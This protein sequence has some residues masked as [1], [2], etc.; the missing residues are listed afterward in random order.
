MTVFGTNVLG[1]GTLSLPVSTSKPHLATY[2]Y[3]SSGLILSMLCLTKDMI[4]VDFKLN[5]SR[6]AFG[7][8]VLN[9]NVKFNACHRAQN[10]ECVFT[11]E[12]SICNTD[13]ISLTVMHTFESLN[14]YN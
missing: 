13:S 8:L 1:N 9:Q 14:R 4:Y 10:R 3:T 2:S 5:C 11:D 7:L 12:D 6:F